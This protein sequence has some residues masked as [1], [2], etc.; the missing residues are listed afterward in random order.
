MLPSKFEI[1]LVSVNCQTAGN[2]CPTTFNSGENATK[3]L[4]EVY[5][6]TGCYVELVPK[7][8]AMLFFPNLKI[9]SLYGQIKPKSIFVNVSHW[10]CIWILVQIYVLF[11][12]WLSICLCLWFQIFI[13][14]WH[15][16][17]SNCTRNLW[18]TIF[19]SCG[20]G[21]RSIRGFSCGL[22]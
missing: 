7:T 15:W 20:Q 14:F 21:F 12:L 6:L 13:L 10:F 18:L 5:L 16:F 11:W 3:T 17:S 1:E 9:L 22:E 2:R 8:I 19:R 4:L